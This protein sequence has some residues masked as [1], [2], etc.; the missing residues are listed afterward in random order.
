MFSVQKKGYVD[1]QEMSWEEN[2]L[3]CYGATLPEA[4]TLNMPCSWAV[5]DPSSFLL[6]GENY[7]QDRKKVAFLLFVFQLN[8]K[9]VGERH[10]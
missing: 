1:L 7:L 3:C 5:A 4:T 10:L 6:R 9:I 2:V 8:T